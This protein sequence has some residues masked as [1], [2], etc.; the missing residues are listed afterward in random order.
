MKHGPLA[1]VDE[2]LPLIVLATKDR[3]H[4]RQ[5]SVVQQLR[6]RKGNLI[7]MCRYETQK[8]TR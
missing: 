4:S 3:L 8:T 7:I 1:L 5:Q 6:A 2:K